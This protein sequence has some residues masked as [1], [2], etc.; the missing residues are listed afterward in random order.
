MGIGEAAVVE[1][2]GILRIELDRFVE[3]R[4]RP[5]E[6]TFFRVRNAAI[7]EGDGTIRNEP[8]RLVVVG[9][10]SSQ[11]AFRPVLDLDTYRADVELWV[12]ARRMCG[13]PTVSTPHSNRPPRR[14][15]CTCQPIL[16]R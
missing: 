7:R 3:V 11:R 2:V 15:W 5:V 10:R 12:E 14:I 6:G 16:A 4:N 13:L 8:N 1:G 9:D